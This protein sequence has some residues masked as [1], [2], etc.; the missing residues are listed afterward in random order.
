MDCKL[1]SKKK[2]FNWKLCI[3]CSVL[4]I[5]IWMGKLFIDYFGQSIKVFNLDDTNTDYNGNH[6]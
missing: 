2:I 6:F 3:L 5:L 4:V 1:V